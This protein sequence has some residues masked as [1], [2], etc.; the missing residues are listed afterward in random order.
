MHAHGQDTKEGAARA[1]EAD[2]AAAGGADDGVELVA[3]AGEDGEGAGFARAGED[4]GEGG[5]DVAEGVRG[6]GRGEEGAVVVVGVEGWRP[7]HLCD[8]GGEEVAVGMG[9]GG[10]EEAVEGGFEGGGEVVAGGGGGGGV[11][12]AVGVGAGMLVGGFW[13]G[14]SGGVVLVTFFDEL[15]VGLH[16]RRWVLCGVCL[17]RTWV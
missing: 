6:P 17:R 16:F 3:P 7:G 13:E 14:C 12:E 4:V 5:G 1:F 15:E 2:V 8:G 11:G 9:G 10:E